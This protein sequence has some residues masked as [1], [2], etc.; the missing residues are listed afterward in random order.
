MP[1]VSYPTDDEEWAGCLTLP[2]ELTVRGR[3][4]IQRPLPELKKLRDER[5]GLEE[6]EAGCCELPA[7]AEME[8]DCRPG[9]VRLDLFTD[10]KGQGGLSIVWDEAKREIT[11]AAAAPAAPIAG[12]PN[13]P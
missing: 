1:D 9:D 5:V 12:A 7:A 4:L 8:V 10:C 3:R 2:R 13:F 11:V 6:N